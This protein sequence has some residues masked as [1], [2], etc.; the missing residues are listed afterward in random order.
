MC[1]DVIQKLLRCL[2]SWHTSIKLS[3]DAY[4]VERDVT[5][6]GILHIGRGMVHIGANIMMQCLMR[7]KVT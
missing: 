7:A 5:Y 6:R 2:I 4:K 1:T 3:T